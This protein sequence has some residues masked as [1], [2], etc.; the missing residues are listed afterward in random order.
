MGL[1]PTFDSDGGNDD[2]SGL[3]LG[4][5]ETN[6]GQDFGYAGAATLGDFVW[7]DTNGDGVQDPSNEPG[8]A[9][10]DVTITWFGGDGTFGTSDDESF[11]T[12]TDNGGNYALSTCPAVGSAWM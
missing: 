5:G 10:V 2:T 8:L 9:N 6:V 12:T 1:N 4:V 7:L 11:T 3:T